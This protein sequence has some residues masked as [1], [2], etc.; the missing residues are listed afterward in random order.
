MHYFKSSKINHISYIANMGICHRKYTFSQENYSQIICSCESQD[1]M[2]GT[3][4]HFFVKKVSIIKTK[5]LNAYFL[6]ANK[7]RLAL[8]WMW[9]IVC[10][11]TLIQLL[12]T[13]SLRTSKSLTTQLLLYAKHRTLMIFCRILYPKNC[14]KVY[15]LPISS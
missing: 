14:F 15:S 4:F 9:E 5:L 2:N 1:I 3:F 12:L 10:T 7:Q 8:A 11:K 6:S 13:G